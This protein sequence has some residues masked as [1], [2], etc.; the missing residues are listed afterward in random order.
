MKNDNNEIELLKQIIELLKPI[1]KLSDHY[2]NVI[3]N[4]KDKE[5]SISHLK[6][7]RTAAGE[8]KKEADKLN[9]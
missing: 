3:E 6:Y 1:S 2:N 5:E 4:E 7:T 9:N 8:M